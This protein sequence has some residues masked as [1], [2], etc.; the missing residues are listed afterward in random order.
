MSEHMD[1][2]AT[3]LMRQ[4]SYEGRMILEVN[5]SSSINAPKLNVYLEGCALVIGH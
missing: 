5:E 3:N 4:C 1:L 2:E